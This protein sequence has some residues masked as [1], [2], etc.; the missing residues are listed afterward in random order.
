MR[1]VL[2][3]QSRNLHTQIHNLLDQTGLALAL[4]PNRADNYRVQYM[5]PNFMLEGVFGP[6]GRASAEA[7]DR[8][9]I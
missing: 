3:Q 5:L 8:G 6:A 2:V 4:A 7:V 1:E 9:D